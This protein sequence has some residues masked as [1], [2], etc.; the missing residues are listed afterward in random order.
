MCSPVGLN[1][2]KSNI[3]TEVPMQREVHVVSLLKWP[4]GAPMYGAAYG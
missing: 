3:I 2:M 1:E 4:N